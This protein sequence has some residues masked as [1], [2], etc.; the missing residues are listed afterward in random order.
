MGGVKI[1]GGWFTEMFGF[2][3]RH[4]SFLRIKGKLVLGDDIHIQQGVLISIDDNAIVE[5]GNNVRFNERVTLHSKMNIIIQDNCRIGWNTQII[6]TGFHYFV[7]KGR[8]TY[9]HAPVVLEHNVWVA[10]GVS[11]MK[12]TYLPAYTIVASNSLVNKNYREMGEHCLIGG[13]PAKYI[14]DGVERLLLK[15]A[16]IDNLFG[17]DVKELNYEDIKSELTKGKYQP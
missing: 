6:D 17:V 15:D 5:I 11:I 13:V 4:T 10:N 16:E 7:N 14:T 2:S 12:G 9:R 3:N 8:L 1:G